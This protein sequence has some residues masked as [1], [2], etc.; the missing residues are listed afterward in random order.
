[1]FKRLACGMAEKQKTLDAI[2]QNQRVSSKLNTQ[3]KEMHQTDSDSLYNDD[4][5]NLARV[6]RR[7]SELCDIEEMFLIDDL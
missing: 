7:A 3:N 4:I 1:M 2:L 6:L 5:D